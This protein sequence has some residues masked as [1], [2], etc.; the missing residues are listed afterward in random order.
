MFIEVPVELRYLYLYFVHLTATEASEA[1]YLPSLF[2][3][4]RTVR[5][6]ERHQQAVKV[7]PIGTVHSNP[8]LAHLNAG[9]LARGPFDSVNLNADLLS[10]L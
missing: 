2:Q 3:C 5:A 10:Q 8:H 9:A 7:P 6:E 4:L 1:V